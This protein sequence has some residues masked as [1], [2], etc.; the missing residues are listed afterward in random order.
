MNKKENKLKMMSEG[1]ITKLLFQLGMPIIIG[2]LVTS[3]YNIVDAIFVGGLGTSQMGAVSIAYP[4]GQVIIGLGLTFGSGSASYISRLLGEK[5]NKQADNTASTALFTS[6]IVGFITIVL[7][8]CF[9]DK[10]LTFL[11]AT[12]TILPYAREFAIIYIPGSILNVINVTMNNISAS[13]GNTKI[14]MTSMLMGALLNIILEPIFIYT[15]HLGIKGSAIATVIAQGVTTFMYVWYI[16]SGKSNLHI[17]I[18]HFST[19]K[20]IY[21]QILKIGVPTLL[22]Q[23]LSSASMGLTN[24][25]ASHYGD[26]TVAAMGIVTRVL[27]IGSYII[28]GYAKGFEPV[29]GFN[30]GARNYK[31]LGESILI[32]L[33]WATIFCAITEIIL[34]IFSTQIIS[35]FSKDTSV[36][37][38]G[39]NALRA[40]SVTFI[41][42]GFQYIYTTLFLSLGKAFKGTILSI[43]R[44]GI[45]F[46][47][48]ILILPNILGLNGIIFTQPVVDV[49]TTILTTIFAL[50]IQRKINCVS[51]ELEIIRG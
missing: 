28:F 22:F 18:K 42:F 2:M 40:N 35:F 10:V 39:S 20:I 45:F 1:N 34:F 44:Q 19:D 30:F 38:I 32:S 43:A 50:K 11:G 46:I 4:I 6:I 36:I 7:I 13:E 23:I 3:L 26:S 48:A 17:S 8:M 25:A 49:M 16:F 33:K 51:N 14:S 21:I 24:T 12:V 37:A 29:A 15:L 27:A 47:P 9:I 5:N 41:L 31:R